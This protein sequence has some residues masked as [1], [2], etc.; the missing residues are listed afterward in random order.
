MAKNDKQLFFEYV[1]EFL[2][3]FLPR[4]I[5]RSDNTIRSYKHGLNMFR[6]YMAKEIGVGLA[7]LSF[8]MITR[9]SVLIYLQ[10]L[11]EVQG[12]SAATR[13]QRLAGLKT[14]LKFVADKDI[15][16]SSTYL[17]I[18]KIPMVRCPKPNIGWISENAL[19]EIFK[20]P[21][22]TKLG[23]RNRFFMILLYD[24]GARLSEILNLRLK[25]ID[26]AATEPFV[27]LTGKG[28]KTRVVP[29]MD[30]TVKHLNDYLDVFHTDRSNLEAPLFYTT[31]K[32]VISN[33]SPDNAERFMRNYGNEARKKCSH[34]PKNLHPHLF[35]HSRASHLY[36]AGV[37]LSVISR[38]LGHA[39]LNTTDIYA[40]ADV[41]MMR[42]SLSKVQTQSNCEITPVWEGND[43]MIAR[44]CGLS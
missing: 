14:F 16:L 43:E 28:N 26:T 2:M 9:D 17:A 19:A 40:S 8:P 13:N 32:G 23:K 20:Q 41:E 29:L 22:N 21:K 27:Q 33:M 37:P 24:T 30:K 31:I 44:L 7:R 25:D 42:E 5:G 15:G 1:G 12:C 3:V 4:Q 38:F 36:R 18:D 11:M 35:R 6:N 39:D 34:V 10:W